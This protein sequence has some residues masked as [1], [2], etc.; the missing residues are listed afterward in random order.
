MRP[1]A[2]GRASPLPPTPGDTGGTSGVLAFGPYGRSL[3]L[4]GIVYVAAAFMVVPALLLLFHRLSRPPSG[5]PTSLPPECLPHSSDS[6]GDT[7]PSSPPP[8]AL[9]GGPAVHPSAGSVA[10]EAERWLRSQA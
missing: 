4:V 1:G 8:A 10:D 7:P 3:S 2:W 9:S 6:P 5:G